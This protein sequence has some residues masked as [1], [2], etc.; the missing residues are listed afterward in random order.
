MRYAGNRIV[1]SNPTLSATHTLTPRFMLKPFQP[2]GLGWEICYKNCY[3]WASRVV[4]KIDRGDY[5]YVR[6]GTF[7]FRRAIPV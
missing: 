7:Y 1:G 6:N 4:K 3:E 2:G 5:L